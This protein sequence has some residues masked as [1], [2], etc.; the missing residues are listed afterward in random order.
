MKNKKECF[1]C[2]K[3]KEIGEFYKHKQM[4][5]G[6]LNKCIPCTKRQ[7]NQRY[8][9]NRKKNN[10]YDTWR[11]RNSES[12]IKSHKYYGI[13]ARS[14]G[15][16]THS[17]SV[18]GKKYL[19]KSSYDK[20]WKD[21]REIFLELYKAW[22]VSNFSNKLAPSIDRIDNKKGYMPSNM[23]WMTLSENSKKYNK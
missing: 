2:L 23:R 1:V 13:K 17:Y 4:G 16:G 21:N 22:K 20:W 6:H 14:T 18:D 3:T 12:R 10:I 15:K 19:S 5:D 7:E 8:K 11:Y 9:Q